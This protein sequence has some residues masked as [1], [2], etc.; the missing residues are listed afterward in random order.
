MI[1]STK[2]DRSGLKLEPSKH[3]VLCVKIGQM[4]RYPGNDNAGVPV[5]FEGK[6]V[7]PVYC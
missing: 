3:S 7:F 1:T 6:G 5:I 4:L 2:N